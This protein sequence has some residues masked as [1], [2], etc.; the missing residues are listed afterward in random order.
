MH[1]V[2][3]YRYQGSQKIFERIRE[4]YYFPTL[5]EIVKQI[6]EDCVEYGRNKPTRY[7]PYGEIQII[8]ILIQPQQHVAIDQIVKLLILRELIIGVKYN[9]IL[10]ITDKF[11]KVVKFILYK[12]SLTVE[13]LAYI[14]LRIVL[15]NYGILE[16]IISN[17]D[18][19][20]ILKF[21]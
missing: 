9:A 20:L 6:L 12:E 2:P 16:R 11:T 17:R 13:D 10:V 8:D 4:I 18:K 7:T 19:Q 21:Q 5:R 3:D 14:F 15:G 1:E